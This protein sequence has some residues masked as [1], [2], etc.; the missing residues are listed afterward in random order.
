MHKIPTKLVSDF[1]FPNIQCAFDGSPV[2]T[3]V[4]VWPGSLILPK[5]NIMVLQA[6]VVEESCAFSALDQVLGLT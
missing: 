6:S 1:N 3:V 5:I 2:D 4:L